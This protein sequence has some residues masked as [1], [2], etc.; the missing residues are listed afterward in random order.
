MKVQICRNKTKK[1]KK[2]YLFR[3]VFRYELID[4]KLKLATSV[5]LLSS[6]ILFLI[7]L[8]E[9]KLGFVIGKVNFFNISVISYFIMGII[10][11]IR[12]AYST[13]LEYFF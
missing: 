1:K 9:L 4:H 2:S 3:S 11:S 10:I 8:I 6:K 7:G 12:S 13:A 5:A